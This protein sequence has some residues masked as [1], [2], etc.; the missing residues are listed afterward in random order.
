MLSSILLQSWQ[1]AV[2]TLMYAQ[3]EATDT[4]IRPMALHAYEHNEA[5]DGLYWDFVSNWTYTSLEE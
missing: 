4:W 1:E 2:T 3:V 5:D